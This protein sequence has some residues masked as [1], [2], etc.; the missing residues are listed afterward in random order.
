MCSS[1]PL[2]ICHGFSGM[3]AHGFCRCI[4]NRYRVPVLRHRRQRCH[5]GGPVRARSPPP[6]LVGACASRENCPICCIV[7][8]SGPCADLSCACV[9]TRTVPAIAA[10][11]HIPAA[12][13]VQPDASGPVLLHDHRSGPPSL[14]PQLQ[15]RALRPLF[16]NMWQCSHDEW[17]AESG[18]VPSVCGGGCLGQHAACGVRRL[19]RSTCYRERMQE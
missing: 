15:V 7:V 2:S 18:A 19:E 12:L 14:P 11:P 3:A 17:H 8:M 4:C 5:E 1:L 9:C 16:S 6:H 10:G 13:H